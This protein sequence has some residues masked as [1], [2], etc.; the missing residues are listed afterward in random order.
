MNYA[1]SQLLTQ[2][3]HPPHVSKSFHLLT[4]CFQSNMINCRYFFSHEREVVDYKAY[5]FLFLYINLTKLVLLAH[6]LTTWNCSHQ[7][8][9]YQ[10]CSC[11]SGESSFSS[12]NHFLENWA[13]NPKC[14]SLFSILQWI[15]NLIPKWEINS[16]LDHS[17]AESNLKKHPL[18]NIVWLPRGKNSMCNQ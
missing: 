10:I 9:Q 2:V 3:L 18:M 15:S 6:R 16:V 12:W 17:A 1:F 13:N 11:F 4:C 5:F 8:K 7:K 14:Y